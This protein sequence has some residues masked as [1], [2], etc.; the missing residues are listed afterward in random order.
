MVVGAKRWSTIMR[1]HR[2]FQ[3]GISADESLVANQPQI[4][5]ANPT[6]AS[7]RNLALPN[8]PTR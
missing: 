2:S 1:P 8:I 4:E 7:Y 6:H 5:R 3:A